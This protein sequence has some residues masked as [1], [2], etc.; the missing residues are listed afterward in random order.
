V[1]SAWAGGFVSNVK[2]TAGPAGVNAWRVTL[3][4]PA[5]SAISNMW[6]ASY[7]ATSGT[8]QVTNMAYNGKLGAG[9]STEFGF[10][11]TGAGTG[12]TVSC[13]AA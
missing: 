3:T 1:Q 6:N 13:T 4:L 7:S 10:Q 12:A 11:G 5:G 8:V 9:Q 2:V